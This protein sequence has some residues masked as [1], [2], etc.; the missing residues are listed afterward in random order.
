M[1]KKKQVVTKERYNRVPGDRINKLES[2]VYTFKPTKKGDGKTPT[3]KESGKEAS[4]KLDKKPETILKEKYSPKDNLSFLTNLKYNI[5]NTRKEINPVIEAQMQ[6][7]KFA[8]ATLAS[9]FYKFNSIGLGIIGIGALFAAGVWPILLIAGI[10]AGGGFL[11]G[12]LFKKFSNEIDSFRNSITSKIAFGN[13]KADKIRMNILEK[14]SL[15]LNKTNKILDKHEQEFNNA[16]NMQEMINAIENKHFDINNVTKT[17]YKQAEKLGG[18]IIK[19][20]DPDIKAKYIDT[21]NYLSANIQSLE[22]IKKCDQ[23]TL[24]DVEQEVKEVAFANF[25]QQLKQKQTSQTVTTPT[26]QEQEQID[27]IFS[28]EVENIGK[29]RLEPNHKEREALGLSEAD[30]DAE[31][32]KLS[33][34]DFEPIPKV[35]TPV[36]TGTPSQKV[37]PSKTNEDL[38]K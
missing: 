20:K 37:A 29:P 35:V 21:L 27:D 11:L 24:A 3:K 1:E 31:F 25:E 15:A 33:R 10:F 7:N 16:T 4:I 23:Q 12:K 8:R 28:N 22:N 5:N 17:F 13:N 9:K 26:T 6:N 2:K 36:K 18:L 14:C 30:V 38:E 34:E 32:D 19:T